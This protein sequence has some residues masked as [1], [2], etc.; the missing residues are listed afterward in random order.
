ML[1]ANISK[2][3]FRNNNIAFLGSN[4]IKA[5]RISVMLIAPI[6]FM[7]RISPTILVLSLGATI[8]KINNTRLLLSLQYVLKKKLAFFLKNRH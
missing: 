7:K 3:R 2:H 1:F 8:S 4:N 6:T 5:A